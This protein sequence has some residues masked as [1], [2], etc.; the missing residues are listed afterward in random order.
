MRLMFVSYGNCELGG[1]GPMR[2]GNARETT[3]LAQRTDTN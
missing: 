3:V 1:A 2:T